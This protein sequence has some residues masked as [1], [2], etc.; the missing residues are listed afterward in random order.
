[1]LAPVRN[2]DKCSQRVRT[3]R[4][5][6]QEAQM[7]GRTELIFVRD[8]TPAAKCRTRKPN[9]GRTPLI[10]QG[11]TDLLL[12]PLR[13]YRD[14]YGGASFRRPFE[15]AIATETPKPRAGR[16]SARLGGLARRTDCGA[17]PG[18]LPSAP[19]MCAGGFWRG[20]IERRLPAL[21]G[22]GRQVQI[23]GSV[24]C[25]ACRPECSVRPAMNVMRPSALA[26]AS[27]ANPPPARWSQPT[28]N[29]EWMWATT[30]GSSLD[31][32]SS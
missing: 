18:P 7:H 15:V 29:D 13:P 8:P 10:P 6:G 2:L 19:S 32:V 27:T 11:P 24:R 28:R 30:S 26:Y 17:A 1:M 31:C 5:Q 9:I 3:R 14:G 12:T 22:Y 4:R 25:S 23:A 16:S 20:V 21:Q